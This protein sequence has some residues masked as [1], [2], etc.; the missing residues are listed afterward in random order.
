MNSKDIKF[1]RT[2]LAIAE[3]WSKDP[4]SRVASIAVGDEPNMVAWG[5]NG[6]PPGL[7]DTHERLHD[8]AL[9]LSL[10][11]HAE[12]NAISNATFPVRT[13]YSTHHPCDRCALDILAART[14][15]RVVYLRQ[16]A[17]EERWAAMCAEAAARL[18]EAGVALECVESVD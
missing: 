7:A 3:I 4:S 10:T 9:K 18:A 1:L 17:F 2:A 6:I 11:R 13:L 12:P 16:P 14:I 5:Y 8:R 15:R